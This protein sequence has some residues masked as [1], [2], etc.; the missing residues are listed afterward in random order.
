MRVLAVMART[1]GDTS[2][3]VIP[4]ESLGAGGVLAAAINALQPHLP[5]SAGAESRAGALHE[6]IGRRSVLR[7]VL[8]YRYIVRYLVWRFF[9]GAWRE[10]LF[11]LSAPGRI[12]LRDGYSAGVMRLIYDQPPSSPPLDRVFFGYPLHRAVRDRLAILER[13]IETELRKRL[14]AGG[15]VRIFTA[16]SGFAYDLFRPMKR[17][18]ASDPALVSRV[19]IVAADLDPSGD[20]GPELT[21]QAKQIG[22]RFQFLR[23]DLTGPALRSE[24]ESSGPFDLALFVGLSS[25]L[26]KP[27]LLEHLR[28]LSAH[29]RADGLLVTDVFTPAAYATGGAAMGY[30]AS[31]Y[32]PQVMKALLDYCG[33]DGMAASVESGRDGINH[34]L[35]ASR[36]T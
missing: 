1:R 4:A 34:V 20:L 7:R 6:A 12:F 21:A 2:T 14:A 25:W 31:Y 10:P 17:L 15:E 35:M 33:F 8:S 29:L 24:A 22:V 26:P 27:P 16:P 3:H 9:Q 19:M 5:K 30:K 32:P 23:G 36:R 11:P 18:A 28:W 13:Q